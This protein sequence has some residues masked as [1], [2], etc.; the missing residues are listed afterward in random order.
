MDDPAS[1][2]GRAALSRALRSALDEGNPEQAHT[3]LLGLQQQHGGS[4]ELADGRVLSAQ[5]LTGAVFDAAV[6]AARARASGT[7][8]S[9]ERAAAALAVA[10]LLSSEIQ[11]DEGLRA[12]AAASRWVALERLGDLGTPLAAHEGPRVIVAADDFDLGEPGLVRALVRWQEEGRSAGLRVAVLPLY[13]GYVRVGIRRTRAQDQDEE[14]RALATRLAPSGLSLEPEPQSAAATSADL[15]LLGQDMAI[16][17]ADRT[18]RLVARLSGRALDPALL[19]AAV[20][21]V[22]SR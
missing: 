3:A 4:G 11:D 1:N 6:A 21:R 20:Q 2:T 14:R 5:A 7:A 10:E 22:G 16:V 17:V 15:G 18:G 19:E 8:P 13:R 12:L 9:R